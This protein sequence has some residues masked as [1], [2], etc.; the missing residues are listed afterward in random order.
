[1]KGLL[2]ESLFTDFIGANAKRV[3][4]Y[5]GRLVPANHLTEKSFQAES[6]SKANRRRDF[7]R[8]KIV[9]VTPERHPQAC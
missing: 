8:M 3:K 9:A 1:M 6:E 7:N 2:A 4:G 5:H